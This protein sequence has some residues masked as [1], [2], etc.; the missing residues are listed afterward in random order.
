MWS[1][2][3]KWRKSPSRRVW[4]LRLDPLSSPVPEVSL[5]LSAWERPRGNRPATHPA[6]LQAARFCRLRGAE[7]ARNSVKISSVTN[8]LQ[9]FGPVHS[10][11]C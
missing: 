1:A 11:V 5:L 3:C 8:T 6:S 10:S 4:S 2:P 9:G 7:L